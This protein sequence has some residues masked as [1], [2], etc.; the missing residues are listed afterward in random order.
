MRVR[1]R[2]LE[3][4]TSVILFIFIA[5]GIF[6]HIP[7]G[8]A[9]ERPWEG[10]AFSGDGKSVRDAAQAVAAA[11]G[12]DVTVL[13]EEVQFTFDAQGRCK[14]RS[15]LVYRLETAR[16]VEGWSTFQSLWEPWHMERP[17]MRARVITSDGVEHQLDPATIGEYAVGQ[18]QSDV[19]DDRRFLRAPLPAVAPGAI[20]ESE[21]VAPETI[22]VFDR[23]V[24]KY[25]SF[26]GP[27]TT[28][29]THV[30]IEAPSSLPL[31]YVSRLIQP[32]KPVRTED[33]GRVRL[34]FDQGP[35]GPVDPPD[36]LVPSEIAQTPYVAFATGKSWA[37]VAK[38]L[39]EV[40]EAKID[41]ESV[42]KVSLEAVRGAKG[43]EEI[44]ARILAY[45]RREVRYTGIEFG[46]ASLIPRPP[47][48]TL[49]RKYG[50]CK[51]QSTL[52]VAML[53]AAGINAHVVAL[54]SGPATDIESDLPGIGIFDH[55]I[56]YI[57]G[58]PQLWIDP[59]ASLARV[60]QLPIMDQGR[61]ALVAAPDT[62]ELLRTPAPSSADNRLT[63]TREF[64][65]PEEGRARV[66]E[67]TE[68]TGS[69]ELYYRSNYH[70][71]TR[72]FLEEQITNYGK[73]TYSAD[74]IGK[75]RYTDPEDFSGPFRVHLEA[76]GAQAGVS[77]EGEAAVA[78][79]L[80]NVADDLPGW[81]TSDEADEDEKNSTGRPAKKEKNTDVVIANPYVREWNY[82]IT[83]SPGYT[84]R[85]L[86]VREEKKLGPATLTQEFGLSKDGVVLATLRFDSGK[87]RMSREEA[88]E[89]RR[90][91]QELRKA[92]PLILQFE[93][94]GEAALKAGN[95]REALNEFRRL[96][97]LHPQEA[98]HR[99]QIARALLA[100]GLGDPARLEASRAVELEPA[101]AEAYRTRGFILIHDLIGRQFTKG[102][103]PEGAAAA[104]RKALELDP[105]EETARLNLAILLEHEPE[106]ERYGA[107]AKMDEAIKVYQSFP[108][109]IGPS[110]PYFM[111]LPIAMMWAR[112]FDE[113]R[114]FLR[115]HEG[116]ANLHQLRLVTTALKEGPD[117]AVKAAARTIPLEDG[118][119]A[120]LSGAAQLLISLRHYAEA[121]TMLTAAARGASDSPQLL[122]RAEMMR[123]ARRHDETSESKDDPRSVVR[124]FMAAIFLAKDPETALMLFT[125][126][127]REQ[128]R[129][130][131]S[132]KGLQKVQRIMVAQLR[133]QGMGPEVVADIGLSLMQ[134]TVD[135]GEA[136]GYRIRTRVMGVGASVNQ[137]YFVRRE[138]G[139]FRTF[140]ASPNIAGLGW[141]AMRLADQGNLAGARQLLDW[142]REELT[143]RGGDD[144]LAGP[145]LPRF[146]S[147]GSS[148]GVEEIRHAAASLIVSDEHCEKAI[149]VLEAGRAKAATDGARLNFDL[150]LAAGYAQLKRPAEVLE[151]G[152]RLLKSK[153]DSEVALKITAGA[154]RRLKRWDDLQALALERLQRVPNDVAATQILSSVSV[155]KG[156]FKQAQEHLDRLIQNGKAEG[157]EFNNWAW[158]GL[159]QPGDLNPSLEAAHRACSL[160]NNQNPGF[161][162][163]L[164]S[165]YAEVGKTTEARELILHGMDVGGM[166]EPEP[167]YWYVFGRIAEQFGE[168]ETAAAIYRKVTPGE[169][170]DEAKD[171]SSTYQLAQ[172]RLAAVRATLAK[173]KD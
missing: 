90:S 164:A 27:V 15:R 126:D 122:A 110:S 102:F 76:T 133:E 94:V 128:T 66:A 91:V 83:L 157:L 73:A 44:A 49:K 166:E 144:P 135:G 40:L 156:N 172:T 61:L 99:G 116:Q 64:F 141:E 26:G 24:V 98:L 22:P 3:F 95:I 16:G 19:F 161:L 111:N 169:N 129:D 36:E 119:R 69:F 53:R 150:A 77:S 132:L 57:P 105:S 7:R 163:T 139:E 154:F 152:Q 47:A 33:N 140:A 45:I 134:M 87:S 1:R 100:A 46:E 124:Q 108:E 68:V 80:R 173:K 34:V 52:L 165:I 60:G 160:T 41:V 59:T 6:L 85:P 79:P 63:E 153:S 5:C 103:D 109:E 74:A 51:D 130:S 136:P 13:Y 158:F 123:K 93:S 162:H 138:D 58:T 96:A 28:A 17:Q 151:V 37:D 170:D 101:S 146:W 10:A 114:E 113:L 142:A 143:P 70:D 112:K 168:I 38:R 115:K 8:W 62:V 29:K 43:R 11:E 56:V 159:F 147:K 127:V 81:F 32:E 120:A 39:A 18:T 25:F 171:P 78:I 20:V 118:R 121:A 14:T 71:R 48:E 149:P 35:I 104:F 86:P 155:H 12:E 145:A 82:R 131:D 23:G 55:S 167:H 75:I 65:L 9:G 54:H 148:A 30:V 97:E 117:A 137:V 84:P 31:R 4:R 106:G 107:G 88:K 72:D 42:R 89:L 67:A 21:T 2:T 125:K 92:E 50:D